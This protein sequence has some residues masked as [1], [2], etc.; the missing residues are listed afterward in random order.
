MGAVVRLRTTRRGRTTLA[1]CSVVVLAGG[2]AAAVGLDERAD[3]GPDPISAASL[4][5]GVLPTRP[6][7]LPALRQDAPSPTAAGLRAAVATALA[8]PAIGG[9]LAVSVVDAGSGEVLYE[10]TASSAVLPASTAKIVTAMAVLAG[11]DPAARLSTRVV[12]GAGPGEVVLVGVG[13]PTLAGPEAA[14]SYPV[15]AQLSDLAART[16][17]MLGSVAVTRVLVDESLFQGPVLGPSWKPSYVTEG[18]VAPVV[19]LQVDGGRIRPDRNRRTADPALAAGRALAAL[20]QPGASVAVVRGTAAPGATV[21]GEVTS[22]PVAQLVEQ[23]LV[24]SDNNL[25]EALVRQLALSTGR[26]ASFAG[27]SAALAQTLAPVLAQVGLG[28]GS[29]ALVDGSGLSRRNR[30]QPGTLT[31]LLTLAGADDQFAPV[32]AGLPVAGFDGTLSRRFRTGP[33]VPAAGEVRAKTGTLNSVNALA[34]LVRTAEG[35]LLAF[36]FTANEVPLGST[37]RAETALDRLAAALAGCG[38]R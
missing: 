18:S 19:A 11:L 2:A 24:R 12:A 10:R 4:A 14:R 5:P 29:V 9:Q 34:G 3:S 36:S 22:P 35:R 28:P 1:L 7:V 23:M 13:D 37:F 27:G 21:L 17:A 32:L 6:A 26:P 25:A 15:P 33:G 16:R 8:D 30:L 31:R 38:C 20:L